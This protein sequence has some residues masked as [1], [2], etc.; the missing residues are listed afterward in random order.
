MKRDNYNVEFFKALI[1]L[2]ALVSSDTYA[3]W[4][5][6]HSVKV[7]LVTVR[8]SESGEEFCRLDRMIITN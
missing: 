8:A 3:S 7:K 5:D 6:T 4:K 2:T 1:V